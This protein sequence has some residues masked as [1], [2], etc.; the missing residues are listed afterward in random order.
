MIQNNEPH[1][2]EDE[3]SYSDSYSDYYAYSDD[4]FEGTFHDKGKDKRPK[5]I[6]KKRN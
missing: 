3:G 4:S 5:E 2:P 1:V 6:A